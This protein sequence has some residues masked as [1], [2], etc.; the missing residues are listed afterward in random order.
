[1]NRKASGTRKERELIKHFEVDG[2]ECTRSGAS[3][4]RYDVIALMRKGDHRHSIWVQVKYGTEKYI[5][6][7]VSQWL[8]DDMPPWHH[9]VLYCYIRNDGWYELVGDRLI[10]RYRLNPPESVKKE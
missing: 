8:E 1:M 3:L 4:G 6:S 7:C 10:K 5:K 2:Y 9:E